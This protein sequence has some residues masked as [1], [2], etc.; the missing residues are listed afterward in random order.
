MKKKHILVAGGAGYIGSHMVRLLIKEGFSPVIFDNLATGHK[1][2]IPKGCPF[3]KGDLKVRKDVERCFKKYPIDTV[4]YFAA[5][6]VVPESVADPLKYYEN[7]VSASVH[8]I[9]AMLAH[10]V[11]KLIFSSTAAVY[12]EPDR[13]PVT[14]DARKEPTNPYGSSKLMIEQVLKDVAKV[15][16]FRYIS[17]RYF[18][19][20]GSGP[21]EE[22]GIRYKEITHLVPSILK[23]ASGEREV[24]NVFGTDYDTVDGTCVRDFIYVVDLCRAHLAA[25]RYLDKNPGVKSGIF[26]LGNGDG[27]SVKQ[28]L[29]AAE[30]VTGKKINVR[31]SPRRPGDPA[32]IVASSERARKELGWKPEV[33]LPEIIESAWRWE[34][35]ERERKKKAARK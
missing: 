26:N 12:G 20:A 29:E 6:L 10:K 15:H 16:D 21:G 30:A 2:F 18:N 24:F 9:Q 19:V 22:T 25:I 3:F 28:V 35:K 31:Y 33:P 8:L 4:M 14:E 7:N 11:T 5:S 17:L 32:K 23:V 13:I 1:E 34:L 27:F